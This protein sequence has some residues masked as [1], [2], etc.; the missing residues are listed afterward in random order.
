MKLLENPKIKKVLIINIV[1]SIVVIICGNLFYNR[2]AVAKTIGS[3]LFVIQ[4]LV[5]IIL[6]NMWFSKKKNLFVWMLLAA[7]IFAC[8]GDIV[9][10]INFA[11][12]AR[13]YIKRVEICAE[14]NKTTSWE[15]SIAHGKARVASLLLS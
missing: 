14:K 5:N 9:L 12:G 4:C 13:C 15:N 11:N 6:G 3:T 10:E 2:I 1:F 8:A 7:Q